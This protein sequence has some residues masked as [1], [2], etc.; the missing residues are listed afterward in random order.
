[1]GIS[2]HQLRRSR[3]HEQAPTARNGPLVNPRS[4]QTIK[5]DLKLK[6]PL[7]RAG[8]CMLT[9][10]ALVLLSA[11][12]VSG[13]GPEPSEA[14]WNASSTSRSVSPNSTASTSPSMPVTTTSATS[15][16][17][18]EPLPT[19]RDPAGPAPV[20]GAPAN[21][22][23]P[24]VVWLSVGPV[25][26]VDPGWYDALR[27]RNCGALPHSS[28]RPA[29]L[30]VAAGLLCSALASGDGTL[31]E[32]GAAQLEAL[33]RPADCLQGAVHDVLGGLV[34][35]H[36]ANPTA[37]LAIVPGTGTACPMILTGLYISGSSIPETNPA[38]SVCGGET[39][40]LVG[41]LLDVQTVILGQ[42]Q[43]PVQTTRNE[44]SF[45]AP[46]V[47]VAGSMI[48]TAVS[49]AGPVN[50]AAVLAFEGD[51]SQ[52]GPPVQRPTE[53]PAPSAPTETVSPS[54]LLPRPSSGLSTI[55]PT[56]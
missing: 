45:I 37:A 48:L 20:A 44:F 18:P 13:P 39:I 50:G 42:M 12:A 15:N 1:M 51:P 14:R 26:P 27:S 24:V 11:C 29:D 35:H 4:Q 25:G 19:V 43:I 36:R 40:R 31:W 33:P 9:T 52:C 41:Q 5:D 22:D 47:P 55:D 38:T 23:A 10:L 8:G 17:T 49:S 32:E 30:W 21:T 34:S 46:V 16:S 54:G 2:N 6:P 56:R 7:I 3:N 53:S 28:N